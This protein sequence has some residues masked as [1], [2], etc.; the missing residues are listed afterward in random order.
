MFVIIFIL[1]NFKLISLQTLIL[2]KI[3]TL[4]EFKI[5][6]IIATNTTVSRND[7]ID[8]KTSKE[9]GGLSGVPLCDISTNLD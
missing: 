9:A 5:E 8:I 3:Y 4:I 1:E 2:I 6:A 7:L